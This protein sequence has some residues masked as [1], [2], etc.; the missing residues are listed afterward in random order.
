MSLTI[1]TLNQKFLIKSLILEVNDDTFF[2]LLSTGKTSKIQTNKALRASVN[3]LN[4]QEST[5][6][7]TR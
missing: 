5:W 1:V 3:L 4:E 6:D 7:S 2:S